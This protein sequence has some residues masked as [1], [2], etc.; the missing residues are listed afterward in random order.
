MEERMQDSGMTPT[1]GN[2]R[3]GSGRGADPVIRWLTIGIFAVIILWLAG[4]ASA[5]VFGLITP[6]K[7]PRTETE[8]DLI[9]LSAQVDSGKATTQVYAAYINVL[10]NAGQLGKAQDALNEA[11]ATAKND[12]SYLYAQQAQLA[13]ANKDYQGTEAAADKAMTQ[14]Q[15]ELKAFEDNNV[16]NNRRRDAGAVMPDS[17]TQAALAK[18]QALMAMKDYPNAIKALDAYVKEAPGDSDILV[19]RGLLKAQTGDNAGAAA[20]F[21][22]ALKFI[23]DYQPALDGLKQIG[24]SR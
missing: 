5:L 1:A 7:A 3:P 18:A 20:D 12:R 4:M 15:A 17:Y 9:T 11:L 19:Q 10:I 16:A 13:L 23:P 14:A 2:A 8:R 6:P 22:A 21:R 24:A